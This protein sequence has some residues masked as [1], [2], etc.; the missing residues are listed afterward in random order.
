MATVILI[1]GLGRT[2]RSMRGLARFLTQAGFD[3]VLH[4]YA[5]RRQSMSELVEGLRA[6]LDELSKADHAPVHVVTHSLGG[7]V[8]RALLDAHPDAAIARTV[9]LAPPNAGSQIIDFWRA[10]VWRQR[11]FGTLMGE[12]ALGLHTGSTSL[13]NT[14]SRLHGR[15]VLVLAGS[16][17]L[18][19]WFNPLFDEPH[20]G[21]VSVSSARLNEQAECVVLPVGHTFIMDDARVQMRIKQFL[22]NS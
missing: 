20:D 4:G 1:H 11:L 12:V 21:K 9:M 17:S 15:D 18:E 14:L 7:I 6:R 10:G 13:P 5:S 19:P 2:P 8:L 3:V 22:N 16:R